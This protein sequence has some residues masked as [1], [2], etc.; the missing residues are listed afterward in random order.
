MFVT[1]DSRILTVEDVDLSDVE[2]IEELQDDLEQ[3]AANVHVSLHIQLYKIDSSVGT[4]SFEITGDISD[5][6]IFWQAWEER[7]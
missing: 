6:G 7:W 1:E 5:L 2:T 3:C 4:A